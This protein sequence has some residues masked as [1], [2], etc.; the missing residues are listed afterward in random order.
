MSIVED[1]QEFEKKYISKDNEQEMGDWTRLKSGLED[2][3]KERKSPYQHKGIGLPVIL[4][5]TPEIVGLPKNM[6]NLAN[7]ITTGDGGGLADISAALVAELDKQGLNVHVTLPEY[8]NIYRAFADI[9]HSEYE[10]IR[11]DISDT[12]RIHLISDDMFSSAR[13]V[14]SKDEHQNLKNAAAFM[15]GINTRVLPQLNA[16][17]DHVLVHCNDW[18]T[19]LV[20][21]A[22]KEMGV[23]SLMTF[24]NIFTQYMTP[25]RLYD[26]GIDVEPYWSNLYFQE[27]PDYREGTFEGNYYTNPVDLTTTGLHAA[28]FINTVSPT[29]L[30]EIVNGYFMEH[31][32]IPDNMR[33]VITTRQSL[34]DAKGILNAPVET[35]D[36]R[37]DPL[38]PQRFWYE[39][40]GIP[41]VS[42]G[43]RIN[44]EQF[45]K[46]MELE[47]NLENP[48]FFWPSR[49]AYPQK[50]FDILLS[51]V[52]EIIH[53]YPSAQIAVVA[54]G[55]SDLIREF[56][57]LEKIF[58]GKIAYKPFTRALSQTGK[59][60]SD[61]I[62]MP[63][64]YE[65]CG[66]PQVEGPRYGTLPIVRTTGGL[67]DTV[68]SLSGNGLIGNGFK[69][70]DFDKDGFMYGITEAMRFYEKS[71]EFRDMVKKRI[72]KES[73]AKFNIE[74]T[75][76][77]Y[78]DVYETIL[79]R[80]NP[81]IR[82]R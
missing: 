17:N 50:G 37:T 60:A 76:K 53:K 18:M 38:I 21:A 30:K 56:K 64:L 62:M 73:F 67:A 9:S 49:I 14:Y 27:H 78:I 72:M 26:L 28:D 63:S 40:N 48:I 75:A 13:K 4:L 55:N 32:I 6:G 66:T 79:R 35:A 36:P 29:F 71:P 15:R 39:Q 74:N 44:K 47:N 70:D 25:E 33:E 54:N 7:I 65:P 5:A 22:A 20:P 2:I 16:K 24:H 12:A 68:N 19:G 23:K 57:K 77:N 34:G 31:N 58:P 46:N 51:A 61:F 45:Q 42:I 82:V 3:L 43:K 41:D 81:D 8:K 52:P 1:M 80:D 10:K 59:A 11:H 69:F